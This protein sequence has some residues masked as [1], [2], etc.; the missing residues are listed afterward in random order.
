MI[1]RDGPEGTEVAVIDPVT[2]TQINEYATAVMTQPV[3]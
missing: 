1:L 3:K 2:P